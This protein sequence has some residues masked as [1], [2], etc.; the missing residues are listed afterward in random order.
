[1][2]ESVSAQHAQSQWKGFDHGF[3]YGGKAGSVA[4]FAARAIAGRMGVVVT[5]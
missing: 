5:G 3:L 2:V 4:G 1:M